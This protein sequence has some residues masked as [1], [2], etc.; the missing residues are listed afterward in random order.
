LDNGHAV[1]VSSNGGPFQKNEIKLENLEANQVVAE[2]SIFRGKSVA[3]YI[4]S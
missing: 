1:P 4:H 3:L 2:V